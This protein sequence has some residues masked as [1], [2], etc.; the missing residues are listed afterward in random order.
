MDAEKLIRLR[1]DG[2]IDP[3]TYQLIQEQLTQ[4]SI[5]V[6]PGYYGEHADTGKVK[7]FARGGSDI[8]GAIISKG[9]D[10]KLY[11]NWTDVNGVRAVDPRVVKD[12]KQIDVITYREMRELGYRGFGVLHMDAVV[13]AIEGNIPTRLRNTFDL[14]NQGTLIVP[15]RTSPEG[16]MIIGIAGKE[17]FLSFQIEKTG[18]NSEKGIAAQ[19]LDVFQRDKI[20]VEHDPTG[21]DAMSVIVHKDELNG[22]QSQVLTDLA[23]AINPDSLSVMEGIG[24]VCIVGQRIPEI[25]TQVH[26]RIYTKLADAEIPIIG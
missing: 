19:V 22:K 2:K 16:E 15:S 20:S 7:V 1:D 25:S 18:M 26:A 24:L 17:G 23:N 14:T 9:V 11:E 21:L 12:A 8:T 5:Y 4:K 13:P 10:A 3:L 6:I